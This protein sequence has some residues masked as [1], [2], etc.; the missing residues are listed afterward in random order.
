MAFEPPYHSIQYGCLDVGFIFS[1]IS[2]DEVKC[3]T[4]L[5]QKNTGK[6]VSLHLQLLE[7]AVHNDNSLFCSGIIVTFIY[8]L[9]PFKIE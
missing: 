3:I 9:L 8:C 5:V 2:W 1:L 7:M 4:Y 6:F